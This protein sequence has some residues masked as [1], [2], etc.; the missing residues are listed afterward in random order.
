MLERV[1]FGDDSEYTVLINNEVVFESMYG[2][3]TKLARSRWLDI[4]FF[5]V[6]MDLDFVS[7]HKHAKKR[8]RPISSHLDRTSLVNKG[9]ITW[10]KTPK[11]DL[12][13]WGTKPVSRAGK[14]APSCPLG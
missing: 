8:T 11:H 5:C 10:E 3:L 6:F 4:G 1:Y 14:I 9:F 12:Y 2:L 13:T 7:V